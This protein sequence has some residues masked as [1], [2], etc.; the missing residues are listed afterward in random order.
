MPETFGAFALMAIDA[1]AKE[2]V[3]NLTEKFAL[4]AQNLTFFWKKAR[5]AF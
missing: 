5:S 1:C 2:R 4:F 3:K